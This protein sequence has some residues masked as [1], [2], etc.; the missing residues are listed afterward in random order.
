[1]EDEKFPYRLGVDPSLAERGIK[2][3]P[4]AT[5]RWL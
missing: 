5:M 1:M 2:A 3:A 4:A